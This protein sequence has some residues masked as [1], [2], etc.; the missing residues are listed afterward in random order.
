MPQSE[1]SHASPLPGAKALMR[2]A[3]CVTLLASVTTS[4]AADVASAAG[5]AGGSPAGV[6]MATDPSSWP[7]VHSQ[8]DP[9]K[10]VTTSFDLDLDVDFAAQVLRGHATLE[11]R[12]VDPRA[13]E[14]VLDTRDLQIK[15]VHGAPAGSDQ[16]KPVS[17]MLDPPVGKLGSA[18]RIELPQHATRVRIAYATTPQA[19]GLQWLRPE[20][21]AD[22]RAPFLFSQA[23]AI[24]ARSIAPLQDTPWIRSTFTA[25]LRVPPGLVA[26]MAAEGDPANRAGATEFRFRM[27]QPVPSL[28]A[29]AGCRR[30]R[31][32]RDRSAHR[33][34]GRAIQGGGRGG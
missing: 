5:R 13:R 12:R 17:F 7:D 25:T 33:C 20:Q 24:H 23:Q 34:V 14:L 6:A 18:L 31:I 30:P 27:P 28:P 32:S 3:L 15:S 4:R 26:V 2:A 16:F 22:R 1:T 29:R 9:L 11:L 19:S 21:T 8:A 10:F